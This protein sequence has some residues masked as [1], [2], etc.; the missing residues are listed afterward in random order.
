MENYVV[1]NVLKDALKKVEM[2]LKQ[3]PAYSVHFKLDEYQQQ[4]QQLK[5]DDLDEYN[6]IETVEGSISNDD[7][8]DYLEVLRL[9]HSNIST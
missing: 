3:R 6:Q 9:R 8:D 1:T 4:K 7:R 5:E 2:F